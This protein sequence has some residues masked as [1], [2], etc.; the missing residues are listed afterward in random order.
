[1]SST[2]T[3]NR[4]NRQ[5]PHIVHLPRPLQLTKVAQLAGW[6]IEFPWEIRT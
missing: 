5:H 6:A 4:R 2:E 3:E 1:M